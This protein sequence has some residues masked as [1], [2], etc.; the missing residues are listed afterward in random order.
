MTVPE[1]LQDLPKSS[2]GSS[3]NPFSGVLHS[4]YKVLYAQLFGLQ[5]N[6]LSMVCS[7]AFAASAYDS[8][9]NIRSLFLLFH[10]TTTKSAC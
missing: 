10:R 5:V 3:F 1:V 8:S 9:F 7:I 4:V 6:H 2:T